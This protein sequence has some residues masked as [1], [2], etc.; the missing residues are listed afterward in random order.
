[1]EHVMC[2][3]PSMLLVS[4]LWPKGTA[5]TKMSVMGFGMTSLRFIETRLKVSN[6]TSRGA[7]EDSHSVGPVCSQGIWHL[8]VC[9]S[10][11]TFLF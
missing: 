11:T 8:A 2:A 9:H 1:M 10:P 3:L 5:A 4:G 6:T 7:A